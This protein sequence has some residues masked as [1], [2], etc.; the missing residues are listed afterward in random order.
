[1]SL[2]DQAIKEFGESMGMKSLG[3]N[4]GITALELE[5]SQQF[6]IQKTGEDILLYLISKIDYPSVALFEKTLAL[7]HF[8]KK[9]TKETLYPGLIG[10]DKILLAMRLKEEKISTQELDSS[11][12]LLMKELQTLEK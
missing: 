6:F 1:M 10:N 5:N 3:L 8:K 2:N 7:C 12:D 9:K 4:D 11:L